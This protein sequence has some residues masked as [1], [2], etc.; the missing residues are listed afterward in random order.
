MTRASIRPSAV[1][2]ATGRVSGDDVGFGMVEML[3]K[4]ENGVTTTRRVLRAG[5]ATGS[6]DGFCLSQ[7]Q[8]VPIVGVVT[9]K[10]TAGD[11][12][13]STREISATNVQFDVWT[14]RGSG[15]GVNLDGVVQ[16]GL[17]SQDITTLPGVDNPLA[18]PTGV[19]YFGIDATRGDIYEAR[20]QIYNADIG[21]PMTLPGLAIQVVV[22]DH[23][24]SSDPLPH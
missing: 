19:G 18:A 22:G 7:K 5:F 11:G 1:H 8:T 2:F 24:C 6:L 10:V 20:G 14:L 4:S 13:P 21:G 12:D 3:T 17:A 23:P 9:I 16:I 15:T